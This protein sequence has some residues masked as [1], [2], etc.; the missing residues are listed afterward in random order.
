MLYQL[1][2][3]SYTHIHSHS[4]VTLNRN[5]T[6]KLNDLHYGDL[7]FVPKRKASPHNVIH[8]PTT[9]VIHVHTHTHTH[10]STLQALPQRTGVQVTERHNPGSRWLRVFVHLCVS[11]RTCLVSTL[12]VCVRVC[13]DVIITVMLTAAHTRSA[14]RSGVWGASGCV[15][16]S[17]A[18]S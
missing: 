7:R 16:V 3:L 2:H 8:V 10:T 11:I 12:Y 15:C 1:S 4:R 14:E 13:S 9:W 5:F 6:L 17:A 18:V